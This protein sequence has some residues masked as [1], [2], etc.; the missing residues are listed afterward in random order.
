MKKKKEITLKQALKNNIY[1]C[2]MLASVSK[3]RTVHSVIKAAVYYF[4]WI[5]YSAIFMRFIMQAIEQQ[6][7]FWEIL[8]FII[9][10]SLLFLII[11]LYRLYVSNVSDPVTNIKIYHRL[12]SK[13]Y[14]KA[15]SVELSC[16]EDPD[17]YNTYTMAIDKADTK[18]IEAVENIANVIMSFAALIWT[19]SIIFSIDSF[20][21]VFIIFP[22]LGNFIFGNMMNKL[23]Y[24]R[25]M[26]SVEFKRR[27]EYV[28]RVMYLSDFAKEIRL[29]DVYSIIRRDYDNAVK[30]IEKV[31]DKYSRKGIVLSF[32]QTY[33]TYTLIFEGV[34][35]YGS[36]RAIYSQS[37]PFAD[38]AVLTSIMSM[39]SWIL[40]GFTE[41]IMKT[42]EN[43]IFVQNL[44]RFIEYENK[45]KDCDDPLPVPQ[46]I[47]SIEFR[48][49][50]FGYK[51]DV[52]VLNGLSFKI[53]GGCRSALVGINGAGKTTIVKL[54]LRL[55]DVNEGEILVNGINIK[56]YRLV[57][58]RR[59]FSCAFQDFKI[60]ADSVSG[61]IS[62]GRDIT[63]DEISSA[64]ERAGAANDVAALGKGKDTV[65]SREFDDSGTTL[66]GGQQQKIA[67]ART[68]SKK[69]LIKI[70]DEP[71][72][73][74]DPIAEYNMFQ[75]ILNETL[76]YTTFF[77]S[78]R[79]SSARSADM[80]YMLENGKI[81]ESGT[82]SE[83]IK[84]GEKY[85][86]MY[87][88]QA[89]NYLAD[90]NYDEYSTL[91]KRGAKA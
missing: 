32:L 24:D 1:A 80:I 59:L 37:M 19:V 16:Y 60:F 75:S 55:Y 48:D 65:I 15:E 52:L 5:F 89:K 56:N 38:L 81:I 43:G 50:K 67:A 46:K 88:V 91:M 29:T 77:I 10:V 22:I 6:K 90:E 47:E 53:S 87:N 57:E 34:L 45:I 51:E 72:S 23:Y 35:L 30:G 9:I 39:V 21:I 33:F 28:N 2:R 26:D 69:S 7:S 86:E 63:D 83:L 82:H 64:I 71:S 58:Y 4:D 13:I 62:M 74:L 8:K 17:F 14:K 54:L 44:R 76:G 25:Y 79:L 27:T 31:T 12:Y 20:I 85:A 42:I 41:N 78:H 18:I 66:S 40:I 73:A 70:F 3:S 11:T 68:F 84:A 49:V 36:Y 61:N